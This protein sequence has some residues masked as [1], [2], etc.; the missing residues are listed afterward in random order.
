MPISISFC[1]RIYVIYLFFI[2]FLYPSPI[3]IATRAD[4][5]PSIGQVGSAGSQP[6]SGGGLAIEFIDSTKTNSKIRALA[7]IIFI[8]FCLTI[9]FLN[10]LNFRLI[11]K[12]N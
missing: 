8:F 11:S 7:N 4:T 1:T 10:N 9:Y 5:P 12:L 6:A 2:Y 3:P